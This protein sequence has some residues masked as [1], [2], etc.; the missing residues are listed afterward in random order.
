MGA[1]LDLTGKRFG[2]LIAAR[3]LPDRKNGARIWECICDCGGM[4]RV[5]AGHLRKQHT[6][7]CGCMKRIRHGFSNTRMYKIWASMVQRCENKE[8]TGFKH[9]GGRGITVAPEWKNPAVFCK[10]ASLN[11]YTDQAELDRKDNDG[12]YT[13]HNCRWV[14]HQQNNQNTRRSRL[15]PVKVKASRL[16]FLS[17][18]MNK[19]E[20]A[21]FFG[22][23]RTCIVNA[24]NRTT[25]SNI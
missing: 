14:S 1:P 7:S 21:A 12:P 20:I 17:G 9:Y 18:I 5:E 3:L 25:W 23:S 15:D 19:T 4:S 16:A 22:V 6:T 10:W 2:R 13:P 11:G 8:S 24:V